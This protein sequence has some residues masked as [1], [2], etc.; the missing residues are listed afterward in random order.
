MTQGSGA[1][2]LCAPR[3][4]HIDTEDQ[5]HKK[6]TEIATSGSAG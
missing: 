4:R 6:L 2:N 3:A 1:I 5:I